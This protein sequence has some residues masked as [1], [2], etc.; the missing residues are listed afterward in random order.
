MTDGESLIDSRAETM[1]LR[2]RDAG[3]RSV[4]Q[5]SYISSH[6]IVSTDQRHADL[7]S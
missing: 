7:R 6:R 1:V 4:Q 3:L 2:N 5:I